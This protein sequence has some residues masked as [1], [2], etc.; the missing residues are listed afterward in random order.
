MRAAIVAPRARTESTGGA[1]YARH[2]RARVLAELEQALRL[3]VA[4]DRDPQRLR[5]PTQALERGIEALERLVVA[6]AGHAIEADIGLD[7]ASGRPVGAAELRLKRMRAPRQPER[8][9]DPSQVA[10]HGREVRREGGELGEVAER[11]RVLDRVPERVGRVA[12]PPRGVE[13]VGIVGPVARARLLARQRLG[14]GAQRLDDGEAFDR[15]AGLREAHR[16]QPLGLEATLFV[17]DAACDRR[18][19]DRG[20]DARA[21]VDGHERGVGARE[22]RAHALHVGARLREQRVDQRGGVR[23]TLHDDRCR[24]AFGARRERALGVA[25]ERVAAGGLPP[26]LDLVTVLGRAARLACRGRVC[27]GRGAP[28]ERARPVRRDRG[29]RSTRGL[30]P[31]GDAPVQGTRDRLGHRCSHRLEDEVVRE[32]AVA[33]HVRRLELAP[34]LG[35]VEHVQVQHRAGQLG[36]ELAA[37]QR[38]GTR[39]LE[40]RRREAREAAFDQRPDGRRLRQAGGVAAASDRHRLQRLEHE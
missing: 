1:S 19:L 39:E 25:G 37:E 8:L 14:C 32:R 10:L 27:L 26:V 3:V 31:L 30:Q 11:A 6:P 34:G 5:V 36:R 2:W 33:D 7:H 23:D 12:Q 18:R 16:V 21:V 28:V 35:E 38:G 20:G 13:D 29:R 22:Q 40:R 24:H 15:A 17:A 4:R 9:A